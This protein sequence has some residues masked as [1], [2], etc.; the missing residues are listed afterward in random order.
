M[1]RRFALALGLASGAALDRLV[2]DPQRG[3]PV[4][5]FG[6]WAATHERAMYSPSMIEGTRFLA[7]TTLP[8]LLVGRRATRRGARR[9]ASPVQRTAVVAA[10]TW[11]VV[12]GASLRRAASDVQRSLEAGDLDAARQGLRALCARDPS[13]LSADEVARAAVESVAENTSDAVVAPLLWG[14][15]AG[16]PGLLFY[17]AVNTL[18]AMVGYRNERYERFGKPTAKLDDLLNYVPARVTAALS[19]TLAP[20]IGGSTFE[21]LHMWTRDAGKHPSPNGG[22]C[23]AAFAGALGVSLG[24]TNTYDGYVETRPSMGDGPP[25]QSADIARAARLSQLVG[26]AAAVL[27]VGVALRHRRR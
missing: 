25:P 3:H 22:Q 11:A 19:A 7:S 24:G 1:P 9:S 27:S 21:S 5:L 15:V 16:L 8:M 12:G 20:R 4:A 23:E 6:Q 13:T 26:T 14:A 2:P 10:A 18:D 17:R